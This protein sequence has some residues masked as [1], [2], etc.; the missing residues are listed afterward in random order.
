MYCNVIENYVKVKEGKCEGIQYYDEISICPYKGSR[1]CPLNLNK[2]EI[3]CYT[4]FLK[5]DGH[6]RRV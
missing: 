4:S 6:G 2:V 5:T 1:R 3:N